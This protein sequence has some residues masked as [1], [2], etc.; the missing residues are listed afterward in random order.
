MLTSTKVRV[1]VDSYYEDGTVATHQYIL[2][3]AY[4]AI[5]D[6]CLELLG[7]IQPK[8]QNTAA[9]GDF[10]PNKPEEV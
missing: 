8:Q 1:L 10:S 9:L 3:N 7:T 5:S 2:T 6:G 4:L